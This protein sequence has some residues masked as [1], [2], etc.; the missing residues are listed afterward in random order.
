MERRLIVMR[1]AKS[2]AGGLGTSDHERILTDRGQREAT[3]IAERL[4]ELGWTPHLVVSSDAM[5]TRQTWEA[6][7]PHFD[8]VPEVRWDPELSLAGVDAVQRSLVQLDD[9]ITDVLVLGHNP[10]WQAVI[11]YFA[12]RQERLTTA[13]AA[14]LHATS[15]SWR[16]AAQPGA[17]ELIQVLRPRKI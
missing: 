14:L 3:E 2:A 16:Q 8:P 15:D 12:G 5:R 4:V 9:D 13:N 17:L 1:H 10:G 7:E 6:M 11:S